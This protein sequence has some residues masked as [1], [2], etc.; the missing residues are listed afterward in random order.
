MEQQPDMLALMQLARSPAGQ[1]L[2][3]LL[4]RTG[5]QQLQNAMARASAG[6]YADARDTISALLEDPRMRQLLQQL[7]GQP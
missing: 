1:E 2:L 3:S 7:G 5:G 4:Q 6:D